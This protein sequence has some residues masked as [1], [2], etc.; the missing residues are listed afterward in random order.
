MTTD[1]KKPIRFDPSKVTVADPDTEKLWVRGTLNQHSEYTF[2]AKVYD[3]PS[4]FGIEQGRVS[5]LMVRD[6]TNEIV[7]NYDRGWDTTPSNEKEVSV[8]RDITAG[9]HEEDEGFDVAKDPTYTDDDLH[10][11]AEFNDHDRSD[12]WPDR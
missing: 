12:E 9:F 1:D 11:T 3:Q 7:I 6:H 5:K 4:K 2:D 10:L 8:L